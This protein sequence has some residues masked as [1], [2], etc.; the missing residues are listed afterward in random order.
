M[1]DGFLCCLQKMKSRAGEKVERY[2]RL[3]LSSRGPEL[4]TAWSFSSWESNARFWPL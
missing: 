1:C 2:E 4:T 3:L